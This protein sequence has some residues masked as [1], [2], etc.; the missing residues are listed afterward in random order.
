MPLSPGTQLGPYEI[1][2]PI[3]AGGMGT[4]YRARDPRIGRDV[5]I[6]ALSELSAGDPDRIARF[7]REAQILG[8]LN[9]PHIAAIYGLEE[10]HGA[11]FLVLELVEGE[12]LAT[13]LARGPVPVVEALTIARQV[14][15][16]LHAAHEKGII[17]RDL[18]PANVS[19]T[20]DDVVKVLDFGLAKAGGSGGQDMSQTETAIARDTRDGVILGTAAYMSPEQARGRQ[21][22]KRTD[23]WAFGC[24]LYEMLA[25]RLAF[26][27]ETL[28]DAVAAILG[29]EPDWRA[30]PA[31]TPARVRWL[32]RRCLEKDPKRRLHDMAD[33]RIEIDEALTEPSESAP[34]P[35]S[36]TRER[37]AWAAAAVSFGAL[38]VMMTLGRATRREPPPVEARPVRS[39]VVL[40]DGLRYSDRLFT[41]GN[42]AGRFALSPDGSRM[43]IVA[44]G[45]SGQEMLWVRPLDTLVVQPLGGTEGA[46]FPFWSAD[47]RFIAFFADGKLKKIDTSGGSV[48]VL[49]DATA[50]S[51][52][53]WNRE[54]VILFAPEAGTPIHWVSASGGTPS[55]VTKLDATLGD[56]QH[57]F[58]FFLPDGRHFL[59]FVV[60]SKAGGVAHP[61]AV[62]V[63]SLDPAEPGR[64]LLEG[65]SNA[66]Y[67]QGHLIFL[68][69]GLLMA[70]PL[71]LQ[72]M[73]LHGAAVP[74][75]EQVPVAGRRDLGT[76]GAFS[77]SDTGLLAYQ[78]GLSVVRS[79]LVWLDGGGTQI[80]LL[81]DQA[82][83]GDVALSPD[84]RHAAVSVLD[85]SRRTRDL[86]IY[87]VARGVR[88]RFT[89]DPG[90][91]IAPSWAPDGS[92][93]IFASIRKGGGDL[94]Q[95][96]LSGAGD[97]EVL[98]A[99]TLG[100][101]QGTSSPDGG[102]FVYVAG[103]GAV[104]R[105][106]LW[107]LPLIGDRKPY[108]LFETTFVETQPQFSPD[109]KWI[110][111]ASNE[112]GSLEVYMA[113]F[114]G[115]GDRS[116]VST[117]G[118]GWPRWRRDGKEIF[119]LA[120]D[121]TLMAAPVGA[122][123]SGL[124]V[125][126]PRALFRS[127]PRPFVRL[128]AYPYDVSRDGRFLVN[129][130]VDEP[131]APPITLVLNWTAGLNAGR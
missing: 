74:V 76:A 70:Q 75:S 30:L 47:S 13:R 69:E 49:C 29:Q 73:Q 5:A 33:A 119:Y 16:A 37:L 46:A 93:L 94:Y 39:S 6:K 10:M 129:S 123:G 98:L 88:S 77:V 96:A 86:W 18:K 92:R 25:G 112:T 87:D 45:T 43:A 36:R 126:A 22:D 48:V 127:R 27:G 113:R 79:Q 14:A 2:G 32:L 121:N 117:A 20:D 57:W 85:P 34:L 66:K 21:I 78:S 8:A 97:A 82:D 56:T 110:A 12:T 54:D 1:V 58:P 28:S 108:P 62:Y 103:A 128:D 40:P 9:H 116:R 122:A 19:V 83:Y 99:D 38:I 17:H 52:G 114:P 26:A 125:G 80:G 7:Q 35:R 50:R 3:G 41:A 91:D 67:A 51:S 95:K 55:P 23:I 84:G 59:Y 24:L 64:L 104:G 61:R 131:I 100:K 107:V 124:D 120:A 81:G 65:G 60:G 130:F 15:D 53:T 89:F 106:D 11:R 72:R 71:D 31:E 68:R 115:R 118:G 44:I 101:Y 109:G 42:P 111:Y 63:G 4:V 90:D 102:F 105:S